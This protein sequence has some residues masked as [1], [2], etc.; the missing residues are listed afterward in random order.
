MYAYSN[1]VQV[2]NWGLYSGASLT[3]IYVLC[4]NGT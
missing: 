2:I 3:Q 4:M 1:L